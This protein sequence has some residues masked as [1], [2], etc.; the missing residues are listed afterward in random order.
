MDPLET[1]AT[2]DNIIAMYKYDP[3]E[4]HIY[5]DKF[6]KRFL[7]TLD[8]QIKLL[9]CDTT[10]L[11]DFQS[12]TSECMKCVNLLLNTERTKWYA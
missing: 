11:A 5:E 7:R 1:K 3:E 2:C 9:S 4:A 6:L 10:A 12:K 8:A